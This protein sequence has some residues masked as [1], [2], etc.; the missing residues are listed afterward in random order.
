MLLLNSLKF[1]GK[2]ITISD[3]RGYLLNGKDIQLPDGFYGGRADKLA[4]TDYGFFHIVMSKDEPIDLI[5]LDENA[6]TNNQLK[7]ILEENGVDTKKL[8]NKEKLLEAL[9][10][11]FK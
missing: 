10:E 7:D 5:I 4:K 8:S 9:T 6:L 2:Q 1:K 3:V 11:L